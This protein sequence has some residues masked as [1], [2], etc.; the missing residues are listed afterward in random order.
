MDLRPSLGPCWP[1]CC[2]WL[3]RVGVARDGAPAGRFGLKTAAFVCIVLALSGSPNCGVPDQGRG[4]RAGRHVGQLVAGGSGAGIGDR[5]QV[6]RVHGRHWTRII[7][8]ARGTR[9][10]SLEEKAKDGWQ[11]HPTAGA[12]GRGRIWRTPSATAWPRCPRA[13][14]RACC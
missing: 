14:C 10:V 11:L 5:R 6:E 9:L 7:P 2:R 4:G 12:A 13:W 3:G 8:F 1:S